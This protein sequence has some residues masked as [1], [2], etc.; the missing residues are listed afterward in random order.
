M[1]FFEHRKLLKD[2]VILIYGKSEV[3]CI[4]KQSEI[5]KKDCSIPQSA[6]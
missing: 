1:L 5:F 2:I 4:K 6:V 3:V